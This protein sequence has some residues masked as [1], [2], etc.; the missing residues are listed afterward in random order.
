MFDCHSILA[1]IP[2][3]AGSKGLPNKN[4][5]K[6]AGVPLIEWT[7][8]AALESKY[9]DR[10]VI[11]TDSREIASIASS[12][13]DT[14]P[15]I[16]PYELATDN[17]SVV[18]VLEH[19]WNSTLNVDGKSYDYVVL[20][21]PTSPL[22]NSSHLNDAIEHY[23]DSR[24]SDRDT[25]ASVYK[26]DNKNG[27]LMQM[28]NDKYIKF[29][30]DKRLKNYQRQ[31]LNN[32]YLPNGAVFILK[33]VGIKDGLYRENTIPYKMSASDSIDIDSLEDLIL[34]EAQLMIQKNSN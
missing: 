25:L 11:S 1:V 19:A 12:F 28:N 26:V 30:F 24:L 5:L 2:A 3:R 33:G 32:F 15:L 31:D 23:F 7:L 17:A 13:E 22:R 29:C 4:A 21:Q 27:W 14:I 16:R 9:V 20:L 34:A 18:D 6:C 8:R 10:V